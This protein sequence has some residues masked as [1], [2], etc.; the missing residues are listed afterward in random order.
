MKA[1]KL[2]TIAM[3]MT[4]TLTV[5]AEGTKQLTDQNP[6]DF[7][8]VRAHITGSAGA[9]SYI[10]EI[11]EL[12]D[13]GEL[14]QPADEAD[15]YVY[16]P[17]DVTAIEIN[18]LTENQQVSVYV[19]DE[20]ASVDDSFFYI[21]NT[22]PSKADQQ[23]I[24]SVYAEAEADIT[25]TTVPI[26][27]G[28]MVDSTKGFFLTGFTTAGEAVNGTL[29]LNQQQLYGKDLDAISGDYSGHMVFYSEIANKT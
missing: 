21:T 15:S 7:T 19:K 2:L 28:V 8:K 17:Y 13:F 3:A 20:N 10:I 1:K 18:G 22:D 9:V 11:P 25:T 16:K 24:Y 29:S 26:S 27:S 4:A 12:V 6:S 23:L 5:A 14:T